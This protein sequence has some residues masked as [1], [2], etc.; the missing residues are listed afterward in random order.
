[1]ALAVLL[2]TVCGVVGAQVALPLIPLFADP[3]G[4]VPLELDTNWTVVLVL[5]L[6]GTAVLAAATLLLGTG[7]NRRASYSRIRE[8]LT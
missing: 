5:W 3:G 2:G 6:A 7:V 1:V 8:E 4:P